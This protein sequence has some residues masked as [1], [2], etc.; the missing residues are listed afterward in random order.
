MFRTVLSVLALAALACTE[1][2]PG[3]DELTAGGEGPTD[4]SSGALT[5]AVGRDW[6]CLGELRADPMIARDNTN[7]ARLVQSVQVLTLREGRVPPE[8]VVR[9][10]AQRDLACDS[11]LTAQLP[12]DAQG[13]VDM[14][15]FDGF[16]GY[17]EVTSP[18]TVPSTPS[19]C[20]RSRTKPSS[21]MLHAPA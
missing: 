21:S 4:T 8:T 1:F 17:L 5:P 16:D 9:A 2:E 15:L 12:V 13:W 18:S 7:P 3:T 19:W 10:C 14:P 6:T 20:R 11:P